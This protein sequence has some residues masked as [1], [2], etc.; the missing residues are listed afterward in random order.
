MAKLFGP[1]D[2]GA[3][4]GIYTAQWSKMMRTAIKDGIVNGY[5]NELL[6]Y[7]DSTGMQVKVKTGGGWV[8]GHY[9]ENDA[10]ETLAISAA[11]ATNPRWD[12]V[13]LEVDW[14]LSDNQMSVKVVAGTAAASPSLPSLT[15]TT[16]KWQIPLAKVVV[17]AGV[18]TITAGNVSDLRSFFNVKTRSM[19]IPMP[20]VMYNSSRAQVA[21]FKTR[22]A[23]TIRKIIVET[24]STSYQVAGDLKYADDQTSFANATV[25]DVCDTASGVFSATTG[26]DDA[27]VPAEKWIYFQLD[28]APNSALSSFTVQIEYTYD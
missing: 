8:K 7:G 24:G 22:A 6:V 1:F 16:S 5:L 9:Y 14:T 2:A 10:E 12:Y 23:I 27:T 28:S 15:Q 18:T 4:A 11:N 17:G 26:F 20:S 25:I 21:F 13:V 3:G 19:T